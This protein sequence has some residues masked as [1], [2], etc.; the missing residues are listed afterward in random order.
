MDLTL[1]YLPGTRAQRVRWML[2][3]LNLDYRLEYIDLFKG[4]GNS[5]AYRA[6]HPLGQLPALKIDGEVMIESGAIVHWLADAHP[7][8]GMA[9]ALDDPA[10]RDF[11]QWMYFAATSLEMP[12]WEVVLHRNI[13]GDDQAVKEIIP[14]ALERLQDV[15]EILER[16]LTGRDYLLDAFSAADIMMGYVLMFLPELLGRFPVLQAYCDRLR[17]RPGYMRSIK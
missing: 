12:A 15:L 6:I 4:E 2:E 1:Y 5:P 14:F 11:N 13:L 3:E 16:V 10:R 17:Q 8:S 7:A 9:P